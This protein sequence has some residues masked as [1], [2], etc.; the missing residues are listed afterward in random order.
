MSQL[1][2]A[3]QTSLRPASSAELGQLSTIS[4][5]KRPASAAVPSAAVPSTF[6]AQSSNVQSGENT[7]SGRFAAKKKQKR[8]KRGRSDGFVL[9]LD[10]GLDLE[11]AETENTEETLKKTLDSESLNFIFWLRNPSLQTLSQL[12]KAIKCNDL[13]WMRCFLEFD[14]LGLLFQCLKNLSSYHSSHL[15]DMVLRMACVSCI[16]EVVN[17]RSG[18]DC[19]LTIGDRNDNLFG[20]RFSTALETNNLIVKMQIFE[21]LSALCLYSA[22]GFYLTLDAL[23]RYK[24]W[25]KQKYRFSLLVNDLR[26]TDLT[27]YKTTVMALINSIIV[28]SENIRDR[29][30][31]RNEFVA[32]NILDVIN[33]LRD[34]NDGDLHVQLDVF[35]EELSA[36]TEAMVESNKE[37]IDINSHFD[38]FKAIYNKVN[39]TTLSLSLLSI[40]YSLYQID[41][42]NPLCE[43]TWQLIE[44]LSQQ[45]VEGALKADKL[46]EEAKAQ[47][48]HVDVAVQTME[49][50]STS[51]SAVSSSR[52]QRKSAILSGTR[53]EASAPSEVAPP[54]PCAP[55]PPPSPPM[56]P[57][58]VP[59]PPCP[60][61]PPPLLGGYTPGPPP[62]PPLLGG[63]TPG[64]P[65]P[66]PLLG[67]F[68]PGAPPP[69]PP[70]PSVL[71]LKVPGAP[72][73]PVPQLSP[74]SV[75][76][77]IP[78]PEPNCQMKHFIWNKVPALQINKNSIWGDVSC[79]DGGIQIEYNKLEELFCAKMSK[80]E[81]KTDDKVTKAHASPNEISLLDPKRS[82]NV[83]IFLKQFRKNNAA[84]VDLIRKG[85]ARNIGVEKLKGLIKILPLMDEA[86]MIQN[87]DGDADKL[88]NAE[89]FFMQLISVPCYKL[90]LELMLLKSDFQNQLSSVRSNLLL[91]SGICRRLYNNTALK[92][93]LRL[94]LIAGNFINKGS[95]AG[96]A[97]GFKICSL[98]KLIL[99]KSN[100]PKLSLLHVLVQEAEAKD[101]DALAFTDDLLEDLQ[102]ASRFSLENVKSEFHQ[103]KTNV[104]KLLQQIQTQADEEIKDQFKEFLEEAEGD[105]SDIDESLELLVKQSHKLAHHFC[106]NENSFNLEEF[107]SAFREF[108][109]R[110]KVCQQEISSWKQQ[111]EKAELRKRAHEELLEKRKSAQKELPPGARLMP[112]LAGTGDAKIVDNL[113]SEIRRGNVLR[114]LSVKR[115]SKPVP[116]VIT[117]SVRL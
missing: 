106:E 95:N 7:S 51:S 61:P 1:R 18:L 96:D 13:D 107:L 76:T 100:D 116:D 77:T 101:K 45:A 88:G 111:A 75:V 33:C 2:P 117:E 69:P 44:K 104:Q 82:M 90:R 36:D 59:P 114:R 66:P 113:V 74:I 68:T 31:I 97:V 92:K 15:N 102:K 4:S 91:L 89:K 81:A 28:A 3:K 93:F 63:Y 26:N 40:L 56:P 38:L 84:I 53:P 6:P 110:V 80:E 73:V 43:S 99:T 19:L 46:M 115:K 112:G 54:Q 5:P 79:M 64:P 109:D 70:P 10:L 78:T 17:S 55:P 67:G 50:L 94:V 39:D 25:R 103:I 24:V 72:P 37:S 60:P 23:E 32:L 105:L 27:T 22:D 9:G 16:R 98:N 30:R 62:P 11:A 29:V 42:N 34:E 20:R 12:R 87:Y 47:R 58:L 83:N 52:L 85:E 41:S 86:E 49:S 35:E 71:G 8:G 65:P 108:C 48:R 21:L 14:G 57:P